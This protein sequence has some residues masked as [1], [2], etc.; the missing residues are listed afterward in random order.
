[1][2]LTDHDTAAELSATAADIA[3]SITE[4]RACPDLIGHARQLLG[5][6]TAALGDTTD[7]PIPYALTPKALA[8]LAGDTQWPPAPA[9]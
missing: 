5:A 4:E 3:A 8:A 2:T 9:A 7:L 1:M 6:L